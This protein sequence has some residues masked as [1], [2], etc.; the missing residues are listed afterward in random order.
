MTGHRHAPHGYASLTRAGRQGQPRLLS[1]ALWALRLCAIAVSLQAL[2]A[3]G[4][5]STGA[6]PV[7]PESEP[8][9]RLA[10]SSDEMQPQLLSETGAFS[11]TATLAPASAL[12]PYEVIAP[13]WSDGARKQRWISIPYAGAADGSDPAIGFSPT[14]E[15]YFPLGTVVVKQFDLPVDDRDPTVVR[16]LETRF[17]VRGNDVQLFG[18]TYR[19]REDQKDAE[20]LSDG[21]DEDIVI[22]TSAGGTRTQRWHYPS[23]SECL[24]CHNHTAGGILGISTRQLN[25]P[26][27]DGQPQLQKWNARGLF[28]ARI[29]DDQFRDL[30]HLTPP[31][32]EKADLGD[33]ARSYLDANCS[34]CHRPGAMP[35]VSYDARF[36]TPLNRQHMID[37]RTVNDYGI[38][39]VCYVKP[40]DPWRSM[41]LVRLEHTDTMKMPPLG[42]NVQDRSAIALMRRWIASMPGLPTL[43]PPIVVVTG[44]LASGPVTITARHDDPQA[45]LHVTR[46]GSLPDDDAPLYTG[47]LVITAPATVRIKAL[48]DGYASSIVIDSPIGR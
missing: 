33:R 19:W 14:G 30:P 10:G 35:F 9:L 38:D 32:D 12:V 8:F 16:R 40:N 5:P 15:W 23:R 4:Q 21:A 29:P 47:P 11:D 22:R 25:C 36:E 44:R 48:R 2:G 24:L 20:L 17:L 1:T 6:N 42:R 45:Q 26:G 46:D 37:I 3:D 18:L 13:L 27:R 31:T 41:V 43:P 7:R 34:H 39:R 28:S